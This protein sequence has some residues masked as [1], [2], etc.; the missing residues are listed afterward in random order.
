MR[1]ALRMASPEAHERLSSLIAKA[2]RL[3]PDKRRAIRACEVL[4]AIG[5]AE[6]TAVLAEWAK[7]A[8]GTTLVRGATESLE[9]LRRR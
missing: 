2:D 7:G 6:A 1:N 8:A 3:T 5:N 9:R 4:E